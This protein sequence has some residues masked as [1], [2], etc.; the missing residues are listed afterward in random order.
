M[1]AQTI[2]EVRTTVDG[3]REEL[4]DY[5][6]RLVAAP[7]VNPPG[8]TREVA[9]VVLGY[10]RRRGLQA[11]LERV[12]PLMPSVVAEL[13]SGRPGPHLV[14]NVHL[15][16]MPPGDESLWT[17]PR[18]ELTR[19]EGRLYGLGMGNMKGAVAA[20]SLRPR[21]CANARPSGGGA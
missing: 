2:S 7:S 18:F 6:A 13:D 4:V 15:D 16:T 1:S 8:D 3:A 19:R 21:C 14:L 9:D 10:L 20:M 5:S 17:V 12:D 11:R